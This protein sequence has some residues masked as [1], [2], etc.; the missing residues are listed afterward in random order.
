MTTAGTELPRGLPPGTGGAGTGA[1]VRGL[2]LV[3]VR[4]VTAVVVLLLVY[5]ASF[6]LMRT[7]PG[8]PFDRLQ[9]LPEQTLANLERRFGLDRPLAEQYL[10]TLAGYL[11]G[12][13]GP[14][15]SFAPGRTVGDVLAQALPV[16]LELGA[17][18]LLVALVL[19]AGGGLVA[20]RYPGRWIDRLTTGA[21]LAVIS[22]SLIVLGALGREMLALPGFPLQ[23]GGFDS[24]RNKLLPVLTLG[25]SSGAVFQRLIRANVAQRMSEG[26]WTAAAARGV[27]GFRVFWKYVVPAALVPMLDYAGPVVAG[28]LT[29]SFVIEAVYEIPGAAACFVHG[30]QGRDYT[31]VMAA[32]LVYAALLMTCN[33]VFETLHWFLDPRQRLEQGRGGK[34]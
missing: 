4:G 29:G 9:G 8:G 13:L 12:D 23:L 11:Q 10:V 20:G 33:L 32:I 18:A 3:A 16:S 21:A 6:A 7:A 14:S 24:W 5:S 25:I 22:A 31:L 34:R 2:R 27:P 28:I 26:M 19:G 30:A 15:L 17:W 1:V